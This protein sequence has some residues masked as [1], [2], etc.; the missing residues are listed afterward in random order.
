MRRE[1][2]AGSAQP[3]PASAEM[4]DWSLEKTRALD[5]LAGLAEGDR[6]SLSAIPLA[7]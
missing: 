2:V 4:A 6:F 5:G 3:G 7:W 1:R